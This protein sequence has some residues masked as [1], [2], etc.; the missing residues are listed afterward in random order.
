MNGDIR[1]EMVLGL[2]LLER[3]QLTGRHPED[4]AAFHVPLDAHIVAF[5]EGVHLGSGAMDNHIDRRGTDREL[6]V[7][8]GAHSR[9][10]TRREGR[11]G[12]DDRQDN[13]NRRERSAPK[14]EEWAHQ[15]ILAEPASREYPGY[16]AA[17]YSDAV[18]SMA[19]AIG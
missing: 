9:A 19:A 6:I 15:R 12:R 3:R 13:E 11:R 8:V 1:G 16:C 4:H 10:V 14:H 5:R 7:Q 17:A 2:V 18:P